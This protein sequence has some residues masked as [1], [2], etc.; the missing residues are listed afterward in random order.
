MLVA[1]V[2][3]YADSSTFDRTIGRVALY[4]IGY[5]RTGVY[6]YGRNLLRQG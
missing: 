1:T 6:V 5:Y 4:Y 3:P 2:L